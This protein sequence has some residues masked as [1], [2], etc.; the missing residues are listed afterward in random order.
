MYTGFEDELELSGNRKV[1]IRKVN[2]TDGNNIKVFFNSLS[3]N[4]RRLFRPHLC[5]DE[6][7]K[8]HINKVVNGEDWSYLAFDGEKAIAYFFL[9]GV[10][11]TV[12]LLGI[13]IMDEWQGFKLGG[14]L[15]DILIED[16]RMLG[17]E[18]IELTTMLDNDKAFNVYL[19][20]GFKFID[21]VDNISDNGEVIKERRMILSF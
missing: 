17:R 19:K 5:T 11:K 7:I 15:M 18:G 2:E 16:A 14:K 3:E 4:S 12:P 1:Y 8:Q 6:V 13:G 9:W 10:K 20:K 21:I